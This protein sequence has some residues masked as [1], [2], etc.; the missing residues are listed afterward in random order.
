MA[1]CDQ[2]SARVFCELATGLPNLTTLDVRGT[3]FSDQGCAILAHYCYKLRELNL[4]CCP[5]GD[6][7]MFSLCAS[8]PGARKKFPTCAS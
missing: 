3:Q 7:G 2:V 6:S 1:C 8:I 5:V 4:S